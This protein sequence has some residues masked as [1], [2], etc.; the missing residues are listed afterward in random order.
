MSDPK[1]QAE[2]QVYDSL[3]RELGG[4]FTVYWSRPWHRFRPDGTGRDGE[5]DFI[6]AH[7][8]LGI[9]ALEVKGGTVSCD[10][11]GQWVSE[12]HSGTPYNLKRSPITQAMEGKYELRNRLKKVS[13]LERRQLNLCHGV[14]LPDNIRPIR[15]LGADAPLE[16][17]AFSNE[18]G[19]GRLGDWVRETLSRGA[20]ACDAPG[21]EG[22]RALHEIIAA[23]FEL[24]PH[25]ASAL[26]HDMKKI[27]FLTAEQAYVLD[28]LAGNPQMAI[29]G[30]AGTGKTLLALEKAMRCTRD[31]QR[32]LLTCFNTALAAHLKGLVGEVKN[33]T[34]A[35]FHEFCGKVAH[36]AKVPLDNVQDPAF[37]SRVL[38]GALEQAMQQRPGLAFDA[39]IIDEGQDFE[40]PWYDALRL[41]LKDLDT[42]IFHVFYD[43]NQRIYGGGQGFADELPKLSF[44]LI[45][46][47]RNT[48]AIH[49]SLKP[50]Y[51]ARGALSAGPAGQP[52]DWIEV[53][54]REQAYN[55]ASV[56]VADLTKTAQLQAS[57]I[58]ILTGGARDRCILFSQAQ[59]GGA[60]P[61]SASDP[62]G[63]TRIWC[64]TVRRFK[65]LEAKC[66]VLV[67]IDQLLEDEL[68][69][70]AL[71]RPSLLLRVIGLPEDIL[72]VKGG[73]EA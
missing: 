63:K 53:R 6:I 15:P 36:L 46:N 10:D 2:R 52:V 17:F 38:P 43:D 26:A 50:W 72:R 1:R 19:A 3:D 25:L 4:D 67:D 23:E 35:G 11:Q 57:D 62:R 37:Y 33:L 40:R 70:V 32:S 13:G 54:S 71:S 14:V 8:T 20:A 41:S 30:A 59:I 73:Q 66:V 39:I 7:P 61:V 58:A 42:S 9:L 31:G 16:L 69:Y 47:L 55:N 65:G 64:D 28:S 56:F 12:S 18:I 5:V 27:G 22:M 51:D 34:I 24:R 48:R 29:A 49:R 60:V 45:R 68:I 44:R 21:P